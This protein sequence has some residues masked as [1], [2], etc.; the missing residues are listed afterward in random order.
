[1][2]PLLEFNPLDVSQLAA[3]T[4]RLRSGN[5]HDSD[6]CGVHRSGGG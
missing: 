1:M 4:I 5:G 6:I 2:L 3:V